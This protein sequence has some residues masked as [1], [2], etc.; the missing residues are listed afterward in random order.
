MS[1]E[2]ELTYQR[3][4][5]VSLRQTNATYTLDAD[6]KKVD[7]HS[8]AGLSFAGTVLGSVRPFYPRHEP[9]ETLRTADKLVAEKV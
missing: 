3:L 8:S 5:G 9:A 2:T 4:A 1:P 7:N 6:C